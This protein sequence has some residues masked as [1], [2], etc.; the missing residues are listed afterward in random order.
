MCSIRSTGG[1]ELTI[2]ICAVFFKPHFPN[3]NE[4]KTIAD[5][6]YVYVIVVVC[7]GATGNLGQRQKPTYLT[8]TY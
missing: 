3:Q 2:M 8:T 7:D 4:R 6:L 1:K 5:I